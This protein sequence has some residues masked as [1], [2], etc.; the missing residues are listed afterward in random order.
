MNEGKEKSL[1][2]IIKESLPRGSQ[3]SIARELGKSP[4]FVCQVLKGKYQS[5]AVL[6]LAGKIIEKKKNRLKKEVIAVRKIRKAHTKLV[7]LEKEIA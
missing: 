5:A 4:A 2:E 6:E 1:L 3:A 7:E